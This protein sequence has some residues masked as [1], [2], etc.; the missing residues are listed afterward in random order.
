[1]VFFYGGAP[2]VSPSLMQAIEA[3]DG[4]PTVNMSL[5]DKQGFEGKALGSVV[6]A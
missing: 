3:K 1:M 5:D 4:I 2:E 6:R